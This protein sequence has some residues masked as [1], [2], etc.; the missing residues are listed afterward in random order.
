MSALSLVSV[1]YAKQ[2]GPPYGPPPPTG[3]WVF[4]IIPEGVVSVVWSGLPQ[5]ASQ[6]WPWPQM[7]ASL[8]GNIG[9]YEGTLNASTSGSYRVRA[10]WTGA[11]ESR[12]DKLS[13]L[14]N[15]SASYNAR[16][17]NGTP[18]SGSASNSISPFVPNLF[19]GQASGKRVVQLKV[20]G[21]TVEY[22]SNTLSANSQASV[23]HGTIGFFGIWVDCTAIQ[24]PR[25]VSIGRGGRY[26]WY[27]S[28]LVGHGDTIYSYLSQ[29]TSTGLISSDVIYS[30][31][32]AGPWGSPLD[33]TWS[34]GSSIIS[35]Y[36][37]S[38]VDRM[39]IGTP[40]Q[41]LAYGGPVW[42][43][44]PTGVSES[45]ITYKLTD[46][47]DGAIADASYILKVHDPIENFEKTT[48]GM[49]EESEHPSHHRVFGPKEQHE[50]PIDEEYNVTVGGSWTFSMGTQESGL[51]PWLPIFGI[52]YNTNPDTYVRHAIWNKPILGGRHLRLYR[53]IGYNQHIM[54]YLVYDLMGQV[55]SAPEDASVKTLAFGWEKV[56][57]TQFWLE[58]S[59]EYGF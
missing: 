19:G 16:N 37:F 3:G 46:P 35:Q 9:P 10:T 21:N 40:T 20:T 18:G 38:C 25:A 52:S 33:W 17:G 42:Q 8:H 45:T 24:D 43:G 6:S 28:K 48:G 59:N 12:P 47:S 11:T 5:S 44:S 30:A 7:S 55:R 34:G 31:S 22:S 13:I 39:P 58:F 56:D 15:S 53:R 54:K 4:Q 1:A 57:E 14:E 50:L 41:V 32:I 51:I 26:E 36:Q 27:D 2:G 29:L 23:G 49:I